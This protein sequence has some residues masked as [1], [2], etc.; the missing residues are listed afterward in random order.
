MVTA[1][2]RPYCDVKLLVQAGNIISRQYASSD[3]MK[4]DT[5]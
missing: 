5:A 4:Q 3:A 1:Y 2:L